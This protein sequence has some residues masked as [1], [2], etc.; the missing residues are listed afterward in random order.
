M[1]FKLLR[2]FLSHAGQVLG[3]EELIEQVWGPGVYMSDRVVYTHVNN[4][5]RKIEAD[6]PH[7]RHLITVRGMGYRFDLEPNLTSA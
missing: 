6:P 4:L 2:T 5:R 3:I 1:E 7:P